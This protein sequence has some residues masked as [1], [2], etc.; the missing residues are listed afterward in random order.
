[1][2]F[3]IFFPLTAELRNCIAESL[4]LCHFL[5]SKAKLNETETAIHVKMHKKEEE[6]E[7]EEQEEEQEQEEEDE[8]EG[9]ENKSKSIDGLEHTFSGDMFIDRAVLHLIMRYFIPSTL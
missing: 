4:S 7:E 2:M 8:E 5:Q 1:M 3:N 9:E 6:E